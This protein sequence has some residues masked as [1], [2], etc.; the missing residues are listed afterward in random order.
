MLS[1]TIGNAGQIAA[2]LE[3]IRGKAC[4]VIAETRRPVPLHPLFFHPSGTLYPLFER[5]T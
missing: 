5:Y 4:T 3:S 2:W 1:A